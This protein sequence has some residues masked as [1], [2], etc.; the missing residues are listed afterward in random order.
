MRMT[1][2]DAM[3]YVVTCANKYLSINQLVVLSLSID[4][5]DGQLTARSCCFITNNIY[6]ILMDVC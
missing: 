4:G 2:L 3:Y 1:H 6:K 5:T